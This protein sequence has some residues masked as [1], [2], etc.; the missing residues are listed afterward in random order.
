MESSLFHKTEVEG[1]TLPQFPKKKVY[2]KLNGTTTKETIYCFVVNVSNLK[3]HVFVA[4]K[5]NV[6]QN[7]YSGN[8]AQISFTLAVLQSKLRSNRSYFTTAQILTLNTE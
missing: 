8:S 3:Y 1:G 5:W 7:W 2:Y 4:K 6:A